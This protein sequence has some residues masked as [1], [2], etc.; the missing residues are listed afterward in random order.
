MTCDMFEDLSVS[1]M[2]CVWILLFLAGIVGLE[3]QSFIPGIGYG[4]SLGLV[5]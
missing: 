2:N 1:N 4:L 3:L 5:V